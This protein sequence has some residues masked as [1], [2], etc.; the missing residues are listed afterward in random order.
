MQSGLLKKKT[1]KPYRYYCITN[2]FFKA[3]W[4]LIGTTLSNQAGI[5]LTG[6]W[7]LPKISPPT[8]TIRNMATNCYLSVNVTGYAVVE[9]AFVDN[10]NAGQEWERSADDENS[11]FM[12]RNPNYKSYLTAYA[13][14]DTLNILTIEGTKFFMP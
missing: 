3:K 12:L 5:N 7:D 14:S 4:M 9:E 11:Y 6:N 13:T 1:S 8:G 2:C 10:N